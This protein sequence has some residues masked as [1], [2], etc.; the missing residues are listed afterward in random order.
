MPLNAP[1][2]EISVDQITGFFAKASG[3][4]NSINNWRYSKSNDIAWL[5]SRDLSE[6]QKAQRAISIFAETDINKVQNV[7]EHVLRVKNAKVLATNI[8]RADFLVAPS[9][10]ALQGKKTVATTKEKFAAENGFT[11][12]EPKSREHKHVSHELHPIA[13][14]YVD[15]T[16]G[17][18]TIARKD[19]Q[20]QE[21]LGTYTGDVKSE[22]ESFSRNLAEMLVNQYTITLRGDRLIDAEKNRNMGGLPHLPDKKGLAEYDLSALSEEQRESIATEN[23]ALEDVGQE[24]LQFKTIKNVASGNVCGFSYGEDFWIAQ[25]KMPL[26]LYKNAEPVPL[27]L[28]QWNYCL[29]GIKV[30]DDITLFQKHKKTA[31]LEKA[32]EFLKQN[33]NCIKIKF[34]FSEV[35]YDVYFNTLEIC[36][37][38][39]STL[40]LNGIKLGWF[41]SFAWR[42]I[43]RHII[44]V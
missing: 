22:K 37:K 32:Q 10:E 14:V 44:P 8:S 2:P 28:Y 1:N 4:Q 27:H 42:H 38:L 16:F 15:S 7:T 43:N 36:S 33:K 21:V 30:D 5:Q 39:L 31:F 26:L 19:I 17:Y 24:Y 40:N 29:L 20:M 13:L 35:K 41:K 25:G 23:I 12:L 11:W 9:L 18:V 6:L 3:T 34:D